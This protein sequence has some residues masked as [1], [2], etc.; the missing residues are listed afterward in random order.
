M[1]KSLLAL[2][3]LGALAGSAHAQNSVTL[4]VIVDEGFNYTS[5]TQVKMATDR[6]SGNLYNLSRAVFCRVAAGACVVRKTSVVP[7]RLS[8]CWKTV[9]TSTRARSVKAAPVESE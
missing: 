8:S 4:Y 5:N 3:G 2:A 6:T 1:R 7:S 9:L